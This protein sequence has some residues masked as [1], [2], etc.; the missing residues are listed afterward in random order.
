MIMW[1]GLVSTGARFN[2]N[3]NYWTPTSNINAPLSRFYH[4]AVWADN[5]MIIWGG[6][7]GTTVLDTGA[8]YDPTS[9]SWSK[10]STRG[11]P[12]PR[13][14]HTA[15]WSGHEMIVWGGHNDSSVFN[16]GGRYNPRTDSWTSRAPMPTR[17]GWL[18]ATTVDDE[19]IKLRDLEDVSSILV[20]HQLRDAFYVATHAA[21]RRD[22]QLGIAG[23]GARQLDARGGFRGRGRAH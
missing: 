16:T 20:T 14:G 21:E 18:T 17:R 11:V 19:I 1:G 4:S 10:M 12:T 8:R 15:V 6:S 22:G 2:R 23:A 5:A 3:T 9:D 13:Y 7:D